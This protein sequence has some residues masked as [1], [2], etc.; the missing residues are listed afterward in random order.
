MKE[1]SRIRV[2]EA[3]G[4]NRKVAS[5]RTLLGG[6]KK[7]KVASRRILPVLRGR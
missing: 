4:R 7:G 1:A 2:P 6:R 5:R 3:W